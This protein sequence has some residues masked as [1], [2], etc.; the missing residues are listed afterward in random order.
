MKKRTIRKTARHTKATAQQSNESPG[1]WMLHLLYALLTCIGVGLG[2][3]LIASL[4]A[5]FTPDPTL[6]IRPL[7]LLASAV[8]ALIGGFW[9][10]RRHRQTA[11]LCG[12]AVG[13]VNM[14]FMLMISLF[15]KAHAAGYPN[16]VSVLLHVGYLLC[17]VVGA[18]LGARPKKRK[19]R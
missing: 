10:A 18:Y 3:I 11:L 13:C 8:T 4:I 15:F 7:S 2:L 5:Y 17:S 9:M 6:L 19:R 1:A 14:A 16:W 12:L